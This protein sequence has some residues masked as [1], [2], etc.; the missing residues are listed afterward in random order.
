M[1]ARQIDGKAYRFIYKI[2]RGLAVGTAW[3]YVAAMAFIMPFYFTQGHAYIGTD[4]SRFFHRYG[5]PL[6]TAAMAAAGLYGTV[7][8]V[9]IYRKNSGRTFWK[10]L[11]KDISITDIF[12][13]LYLF[14]LLVSYVLSRYPVTARMGNG[15]WYMGLLPH[16]ALI[17]S[18]FVLSRVFCG[19]RIFFPLIMA[20]TSAV[21]GLGVLNRF[22][23]EPIAMESSSPA[24]ISTIGNMNWYCGYWAVL[25]WIGILFFW[26]RRS[27]ASFLITFLCGLVMVIGL[28]TGIT[29]GS[30]SGILA[31][32]AGLLL[33]FF[34]S[35][36]GSERMKK[37]LEIMILLS[38]TCT[39][40]YI[41]NKV[42][43]EACNYISGPMRLLTQTVLP[44]A[45]LLCS[46]VLYLLVN[47]WNREERYPVSF[48]EKAGKLL[49]ITTAV[50]LGGYIV[51]G[52]IN[53]NVPGGLGVLSGSPL[54]TFDSS[55]ASDRGGTWAV[56]IEVWKSQDFV[57]R[58]FG[59]GPDCMG[60][61]IYHGG[62]A[63][64]LDMVTE[65]FGNNT[66]LNA[67]GEW[68]TNMVNLGL[69]GMAAFGGL[70]F[71]AFMRFYRKGK[72]N[73][74]WYLFAFCVLGYTVNNIFSFQTTLNTTQLFIMLGIGES[75]LRQEE[76]SRNEQGIV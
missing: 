17:A 21:F 2:T 61:Y 28:A 3:L 37:F 25:V 54:F 62:N 43:P 22:G 46:V 35:V 4:K 71:N 40:G 38:L 69:A 23:V 19:A 76:R 66:L 9:Q 8:L 13:V 64:V 59:V 57:H 29:Q 1:K 65:L 47:V 63:H 31:L 41:V 26:N 68:I 55:W 30:D 60:D 42:F 53:T 12:M 70:I 52:L 44:W 48:M 5:F 16:L 67:H 36:P 51:I 74:Y 11:K 6:I 45:M 20:V 75:L 49:M 10:L 39:A 56:G 73:P 18:Y 24:F 15:S 72:E 33:L 14:A 32:A 58:L 27:K 7:A 34:I 50:L